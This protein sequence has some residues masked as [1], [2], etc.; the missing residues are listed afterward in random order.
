MLMLSGC[1][2]GRFFEVPIH[3]IRASGAGTVDIELSSDWDENAPDT[4]MVPDWVWANVPPSCLT[5]NEWWLYDPDVP[6]TSVTQP[7]WWD[8][9]DISVSS[10]S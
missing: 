10:S 8:V 7:E 5:L 1:T 4:F 6:S 9:T 2:G 3:S